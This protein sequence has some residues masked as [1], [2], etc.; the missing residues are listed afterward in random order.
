MMTR[1]KNSLVFSEDARK[2]IIAKMPK[3][4]LLRKHIETNNYILNLDTFF[5]ANQSYKGFPEMVDKECL[6]INTIMDPQ[7]PAKESHESRKVI[8]TKDLDA[9]TLVRVL[10][11]GELKKNESGNNRNEFV[12]KY[13]LEFLFNNCDY[14]IMNGPLPIPGDVLLYVNHFGGEAKNKNASFERIEAEKCCLF[15]LKIDLSQMT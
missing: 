1:Q 6:A 12:S 9:G 3:N 14:A 7:H 15:V 5:T 8:A 4:S 10:Y 2:E 13:E 11:P